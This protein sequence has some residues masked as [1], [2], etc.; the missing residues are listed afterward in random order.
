MVDEEPILSPAQ[1]RS[2]RAWLS[3]SQD[4]LSAKSGVSQKSIARY[5]RGRSVPHASTLKKLQ[6]AFEMEGMEFL[7]RGMVG[8]G[9]N[10]REQTP[11]S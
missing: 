10:T 11:S 9:I 8:T 3:W 1:V 5:E 2:A 7:R 6:A 4:Q